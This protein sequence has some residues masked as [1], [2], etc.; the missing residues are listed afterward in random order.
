MQ[1]D[2]LLPDV[3]FGPV[4][5]HKYVNEAYLTDNPASL[6]RKT[7]NIPWILGVTS[8]EGALGSVSTYINNFNFFFV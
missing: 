1:H 8:D 5:E 6:I 4:I 2:Y 3:M 7:K